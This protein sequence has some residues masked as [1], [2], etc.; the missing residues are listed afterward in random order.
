MRIGQNPAKAAKTVEQPERITVAV[1]NYIPF[2]SGYYAEG[3]DVLK[4]CLSTARAGA[5]LP[6]DLMV[7][8]NGSCP[9]VQNEL[10]KMHQDG[11]IQFLILSDKNLG[12]GGAWNVIFT[13]APGELIVYADSDVQ[14]FPGWLARS[15]EIL[16][17][18][19][20]V[21]M[22]TARPFRQ[23]VEINSF[24][25][26]WGRNTPGVIVNEGNFLDWETFSSFVFSL[27]NSEE[28]AREWYETSHDIRLT[29]SGVTAQIGA[30]HWQFL[31]HKATM[32]EFLPFAMDRPMGQVRQL[33]ERM[34]AAGYLRLMLPEPFAQNM[35]NT[36]PAELRA[37][38]PSAVKRSQV[39]AQNSLLRRAADLA[40]VRKVLLGFYDRI[41]RLYN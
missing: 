39:K 9:E 32:Q 5:G 19:P 22:V 20:K 21:G 16:E 26:E 34:N 41:F 29:C 35:S 15:V 31:T 7:F 4:A 38:G 13:G 28:Q 27:G 14:F 36:L 8:D 6:F 30:S 10:V 40:P 2:L 12:K 18:F 3:L 24:T 11:E 25:E 17:T 1:L 23:R 33:D 37:G